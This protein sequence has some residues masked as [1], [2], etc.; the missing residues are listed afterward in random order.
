MSNPDLQA[1]NRRT[2]KR[3]LFLVAGMFGFVF[4]LVPLYNV[5]CDLT[6][7]NG[8]TADGP[9]QAVIVEPDLSRTV[10]VEFL[11]SVNENMP[12]DFRPSVVRMEI[13]PGKM[14]RTS[15]VARNR[16]DHAMVGQ[17]IPSVTPGQA[18]SHF[19]KTECFCFTQQ[20]FEAGEERDMPL[21]FM[22]DPEL[23]RDINEVTLA[24]TFFDKNKLLN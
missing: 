18:A 15:F 6:G 8:K 1:A 22:V 11:A 20:K 21:V 19:K 16:T 5:F 4:A 3:L 7:L 24:Y 12:W 23:P 17:A 14:Y 13:H 2:I 10:V 9:A